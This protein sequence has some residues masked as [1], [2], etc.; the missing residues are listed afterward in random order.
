V[1]TNS[2]FSLANKDARLSIATIISV[3]IQQNMDFRRKYDTRIPHLTERIHEFLRTKH[4]TGLVE[5]EF[6][7]DEPTGWAILTVDSA[8]PKLH[9]ELDGFISNLERIALLESERSL[10]TH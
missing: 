7:A 8:D 3:W 2:Y 6:Q 10:S 9:H 5:H 4:H 1:A